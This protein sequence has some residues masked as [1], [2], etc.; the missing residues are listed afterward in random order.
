MTT[1]PM[2]WHVKKFRVW[3]TAELI[4]KSLPISTHGGRGVGEGVRMCVEMRGRERS[5]DF[6]VEKLGCFLSDL[7]DNSSDP[8]VAWDNLITGFQATRFC[9]FERDAE[10]RYSV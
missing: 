5:I 2:C 1:R 4:E 9:L 10:S 8:R 6:A 7:M 3:N